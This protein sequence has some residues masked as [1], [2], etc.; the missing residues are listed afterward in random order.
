MYVVSVRVT[1]DDLR[2]D[3]SSVVKVLES[4]ISNCVAESGVKGVVVGLSG[5]VDSS[6]TVT[7]CVRAL[8]SSRVYGLIMPDTTVTPE[9]D[10]RDA[11]DLARKLNIRYD[12]IDIHPIYSSY[13]KHVPAYSDEVVVAN[14]NLRARIRMTILYYYANKFNYLVAGTGD[15]SEIL[16]GY[17]T[18]YG[19]GGVDILPIGCLYKTQVRML[20]EYLGL[21]K[22]IVYKP[23]SPRLWT[24]HEAEK[25]LGMRY[26][27]IDLV[28]YS[29][30]D[31][32]I[33]PDDVPK[34]TG[35]DKS[36]VKRVLEMYERSKHKR[37]LPPIPKIPRRK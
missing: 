18:K 13:A 14:G 8:G 37:S 1:I 30:F 10:V 28:L 17:F 15:R 31:L 35:V 21:P 5:G 26:E 6:V 7:L 3:W 33:P 19:D 22:H 24:G 2:L 4:F 16:I 11:I 36:V 25:E 27:D 12:V 29:I 9:V 32:N 23:S 34:V 20:G